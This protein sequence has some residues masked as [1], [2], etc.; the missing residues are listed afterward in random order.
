MNNTTLAT[1]ALALAASCLAS[2]SVEAAENTGRTGEAASGRASW[3]DTITV[4]GTRTAT[5]IQDNPAAVSVIDRNQIEQQAPESIAELLRDVPGVTLIDAS[6]PGMKRIR[7]RGESSQRVTILVDGQ[8]I[9]DHSTYGTPILVDPANVERIEVVRGPASVLYGAK[10]IGG[11]INIIT[12]RGASKP[13]ELEVGGAWYSGSSGRQGWSAVSGTLGDFDYRVSASGDRHGDRKVPEGPYS[14]SGRL[15]GSAYRNRDVALHLGYTLGEKRNHYLAL[16]ANQHRLDTDSWTDPSSY[17]YP[18][19]DFSIELPKRDL[20]KV[21][22]YYTG[23]DLSPIVRKVHVDAYY[24][25]VDRL[26]ANRVAMRPTPMINVGVTS[27][28]DDRNINYGGTAQVDLQLHPS[29]YTIAG[30]HYLMDDLDTAKTSETRT[31]IGPRPP[32]AVSSLRQDRASI[33][34]MSAFL[35]DEWSLAKDLKLIGGLRYYHVKASLSETSDPARAGQGGDTGKLVKSLGLTYTGVS[36]TTLRALYSEGYI[37]PTL[38][39]MF[40]DTSAGR[41]TLTYGNPNLSPETSRNIEIGARYSLGGLTLD[42]TA[43]Y[44]RAKNY[45][46][47]QP[48]AGN[49]ACQAA[50]DPG[51]YI[52]VNADGADTHGLELAAEYAIPGTSFTPYVSGAWTRRK[53]KLGSLSTYD[54]DTPA[55]TGRI[56]LRYDN[57]LSGV[58]VWADLFTRASTQSRQTVASDGVATTRRLPGWGTLNLALGAARGKENR[59]QVAVHFNNILDKGYRASMEELPATGRNVVVTFQMKF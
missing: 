37:T 30:V 56:G 11:V 2:A 35:Q 41:G 13:I 59:Q 18:V 55:L 20:T 50:T 57:T 58:D 28:S 40:T 34:T 23:E 42:A 5:S 6:A 49:A 17:E 3:L 36:N 9:T 24:Q 31:A 53:L 32:S 10:A 7:I 16:K 21:G 4:A 44:M 38:L 1:A 27:T 26:F 45:I 48:C 51:G 47:T 12:R 52:Y 39:Q 19:T 8:E 43:Y 14:A 15:E 54:S 29:H 25:T 46:T 33:R 22:L